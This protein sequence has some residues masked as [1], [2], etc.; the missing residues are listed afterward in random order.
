MVQI[1]WQEET[2]WMGGWMC[3]QVYGLFTA[4][5]RSLNQKQLKHMLDA[6]LKPI[7]T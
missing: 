6:F 5:K 2:D 4:I 7:L 1:E 3:E